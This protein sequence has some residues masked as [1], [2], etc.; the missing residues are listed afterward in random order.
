MEVGEV[1]SGDLGPGTVVV[2]SDGELQYDLTQQSG[3]FLTNTHIVPHGAI[4]DGSGTMLSLP[5]QL[6]QLHDPGGDVGRTGNVSSGLSGFTGHIIIKNNPDGTRTFLLDPS[7]V[8]LSVSGDD[9]GESR[10]IP[11]QDMSEETVGPSLNDLQ[12][13]NGFLQLDE[14]MVTMNHVGSEIGQGGV[15]LASTGDYLSHK[16]GTIPQFASLNI[17][18]GQM[19][20]TATEA[21]VDDTVTLEGGNLINSAMHSPESILPIPGPISIKIEP[22][23]DPPVGRG[24][25]MCACCN[26]AIEKWQQYKKHLKKHLDDKPYQC[27]E[28]EASFNVQKNLRLHEALHVS[29]K[30]ICPECCKTF[31]RLASFKAHLVVHEEDESV[32]CE[33][34][35]EEFVSVSQLEPHYQHHKEGLNQAMQK[36]PHLECRMCGAEF[37]NH[38]MLSQHTKNHKKVKKMTAPKPKKRIDRSKFENKCHECGKNFIKP[39]QLKRHVLIHT[40]E[41][42]FKCTFPGCDRAFN[43]KYTMLIHMD[44]HT[45][46]KDYKCEFCNKDFVQKSNLRCHIKRVHPVNKVGQQLFECEEC[47]CV[48]KRAGSLNAHIARAHTNEAVIR[49]DVSADTRDV[50]KDVR[51]VMKDIQDSEKVCQRDQKEPLSCK[52]TVKY[53]QDHPKQQDTLSYVKNIVTGVSES[54]ST[55]APESSSDGDILQQALKNIGLSQP[56][57]PL[58][59][60]RD[61]IKLKIEAE[62]GGQLDDSWPLEGEIDASRFTECKKVRIMTL[63]DRNYETGMKRYT[64]L[65]KLVG[66]V[67]WHVCMHKD[68]TKEFKKPS[69][70]VRHMRT[71]TNDKP[72]KCCKCYRAF[73]VK[74]TLVAHMKT[75]LAVKEHTCKQCNKKF[76]TTTSLRVHSWVHTGQK[77]YQCSECNKVFRTISHRK[78]H[79]LAHFHASHRQAL[80]K[81]SIPLPDIPLQEPILITTEGP[82]KQLSRHSQIY[83]SESG[84]APPDRPH[85]CRYCL[86]AFKK[87]S[88]LKQHE[89]T[90][91]GERPFKCENC[92]KYFNSLSVLKSHF[93][94][95]TGQRSHRCPICNGLFAT[96]GSLRRHR[97][98]H[99]SDRPYM[100][101]YCQKTFKT[102]TNCKK[103]MKTHKHELAMEAVRAAG[104]NLQGDNQQALLTTSLYSQQSAATNLTDA[105]VIVPD[106]TGM[107]SV[108]H[109]GDFSLPS[110]LQ[111]QS[112][113]QLQQ[114]HQVLPAAFT[115]SVGESGLTLADLQTRVEHSLASGETVILG[116]QPATITTHL[117][118]SSILLPHSSGGQ[119]STG[120]SILLPHSSSSIVTSASSVFHGTSSTSVLQGTSGSSILLQSSSG[121]GSGSSVSSQLSQDDR[122]TAILTIP[123][124]SGSNVMTVHQ[125]S[126]IQ[127]PARDE[128]VSV[129]SVIQSQPSIINQ[130]GGTRYSTSI[131]SRQS[132]LD[133]AQDFSSMGDTGGMEMVNLPSSM[134]GENSQNEYGSAVLQTNLQ[135][136]GS[137]GAVINPSDQVNTEDTNLAGKSVGASTGGLGSGLVESDD[138][139]RIVASHTTSGTC[140]SDA[141][142]E[143]AP[144]T[145]LEASFDHQGF[146]DGFTLHVPPGIDLSSLGHGGEIP[147]S[148]LVQLLNTQESI[149][150]VS[151]IKVTTGTSTVAATPSR[152]QEPPPPEPVISLSKVYECTDCKKTFRKLP[153]LRSHR[154]IHNQSKTHCSICNKTCSSSHEF[155]EHQREHAQT[156]NTHQCNNCSERFPNFNQL[157]KHM[158]I[159]HSSVW[160]CPVCGH[161]FESSTRFQKH[162][163]SHNINAINEAITRTKRED[164]SVDGKVKVT[165]SAEEMDAILQQTTGSQ[166]NMEEINIKED[167]IDDVPTAKQ[168]DSPQ[169]DVSLQVTFVKASDGEE[170]D[171]QKHA[172]PCKTC[173]KSFKKPSDLVRHIRTHTGERPFSCVLCRKS[174]AVKSTLDVHMKTHSGKKDFMCHICNTMFATK[175]SLSIHMRLHTGDKPFNCNQCGMKFRTSGHRKAHVV[176][177]FK[178]TQ[179]LS[180]KNSRFVTT[181]EDP[182]ET[183]NNADEAVMEMSN[184][185]SLNSV[186]MMTEGTVSLQLQG[187]N[188]GTIDPSSLLNIQPMTLDE[189][190]LSQLQ[191]SGVTMMGAGEGTVDEDAEDSISVNPNVVMT[192]PRSVRTPNTDTVDD[193]DFEI[194]M[195]D[196]DGRVIT[197]HSLNMLGQHLDRDPAATPDTASFIPPELHLSDLAIPGPNNTIQCALCSK[198]FDKLSDWQEHLISHNIFIKVGEDGENV[199]NET[200]DSV[201]IPAASLGE[202]PDN[203]AFQTADNE[204]NHSGLSIGEITLSKLEQT[205]SNRS[206]KC[207]IPECG[208][209]IKH[210]T[211][212]EQHTASTH[213]KHHVCAKCGG[214]TFQSAAALQKHIKMHHSDGKGIRCVF[215]VEEFSVRP[216]LHQHI[217]QEHLQLALENPL[218]IEKVGL[219]INLTSE[220][221]RE[222][223]GAHGTMED[224]D[225][226][227]FF[228][229]VNNGAHLE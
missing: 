186:V 73:A 47:S 206:F 83:P 44:I 118:G 22:D 228:P 23:V 3:S 149:T 18:D 131:A 28:C 217:I 52:P 210:E 37:D 134:I 145:L 106:L 36:R 116:S 141:T 57:D 215:C 224:L 93:K 74:S 130:S 150:E 78:A 7:E 45:G 102:N 125:P 220:S 172:H 176:K 229:S 205:Q 151:T 126:V 54:A 21:G 189:S 77:P 121:K 200:H 194:H 99:S 196:S 160:R 50:F 68:C 5:I 169:D 111:Q 60:N 166:I 147:S 33:I 8:G 137:R 30:L 117:N 197:T 163:R 9:G 222:G 109:E 43:Q 179:P 175:G 164:I 195:I 100:C 17:V 198:A 70:L 144:T 41:R 71:H 88:H 153:H 79:M 159:E 207:N 103:H 165:L 80:R 128:S 14:G 58:Q 64:V 110:E 188:L 12:E 187:L 124:S 86:A 89:R 62:D 20:L 76:A 25:F 26:M 120:S 214:E 211:S 208:K 53:K 203:N 19:V 84:E 32:T 225:P 115:Q 107:A 15:I 72:F 123:H 16:D 2:G 90:H 221:Q 13:R 48:F 193:D 133:H 218:A 31:R 40:G 35:Q 201:V 69:D 94:T 191:A 190:V 173:G 204:K 158:Q 113:Q 185:E 34:C 219:K 87:S 91:T 174:F 135:L 67:K 104:S 146:S 10:L 140:T 95:H 209:T 148:Q 182:L 180:S 181:D 170:N 24:P 138:E 152:I 227:E 56:R 42:P 127:G 183:G 101:P 142:N 97:T 143:A 59:L 51:D 177:H 202:V 82:V 156:S 11:L 61:G 75:H 39:S 136:E 212:L 167:I 184:E 65:V 63:I 155:K 213:V 226:L 139:G 112:Q 96:S 1:T 122:G 216:A 154:R 119:G 178:T 49:M 66:D 46:R 161:V 4:T 108:F 6:V 162:L 92:N 114:D 85:K 81:K 29:E 223:T 55:Q 168:H 192:Q 105:E 157:L 171:S 38:A 129:T 199:E 98:T 132:L 27:C